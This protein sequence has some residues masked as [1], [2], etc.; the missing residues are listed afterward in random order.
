VAIGTHDLDTLAPPFTYEALKPEEIRF[1]P[2][3]A[4]GRDENRERN[5]RELLEY[6]MVRFCA[7]IRMKRRASV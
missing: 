4:V 5:A 3:R 7:V 2:L 1:L 6:Y